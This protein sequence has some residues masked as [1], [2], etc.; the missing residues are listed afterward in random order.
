MKSW[1]GGLALTQ[2]SVS[3]SNLYHFVNMSFLYVDQEVV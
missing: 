2:A 3:V 1:G